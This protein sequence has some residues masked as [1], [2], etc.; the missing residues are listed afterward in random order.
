MLWTVLS[1]IFAG[2]SLALAVYLGITNKKRDEKTG[3]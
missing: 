1:I 3:H 2:L